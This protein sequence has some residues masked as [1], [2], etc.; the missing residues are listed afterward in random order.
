VNVAIAFFGWFFTEPNVP[1]DRHRNPRQPSNW[2]DLG[3]AAVDEQFDARDVAAFVGSQE[4]NHFG[5]LV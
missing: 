4:R 3:H 2:L 5:D 1:L